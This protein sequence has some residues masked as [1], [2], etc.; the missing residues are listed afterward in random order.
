MSFREAE[1]F[2]DR[3][4]MGFLAKE[5]GYLTISEVHRL[6]ADSKQAGSD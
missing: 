2:F 3:N 4:F 5:I 6:L 1:E